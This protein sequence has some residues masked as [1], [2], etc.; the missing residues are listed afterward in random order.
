M[1]EE[2]ITT[3]DA[4]TWNGAISNSTMGEG[5]YSKI[6]NYFSKAGTYVDRDQ[7]AVDAD[8]ASIFG[9]EP[10]TALKVIFG[11]RL[12]TRKF[13]NIETDDIQTGYGRRDE[14]YKAINWLLRTNP[15][16]VYN[17]LH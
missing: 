7:K 5:K 4:R 12:I 16:V 11:L 6:L 17:N 2:I 9:D 13:D 14:F 3:D 10:S 1:G 8:M 15:E